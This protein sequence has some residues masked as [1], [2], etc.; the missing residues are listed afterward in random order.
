VLYAFAFAFEW[1]NAIQSKMEGWKMQ[2]WKMQGQTAS[3]ENAGV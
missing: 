2:E 1:K 3:V